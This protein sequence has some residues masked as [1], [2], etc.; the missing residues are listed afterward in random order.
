MNCWP[1]VA[2]WE[3]PQRRFFVWEGTLVQQTQVNPSLECENKTYYYC[4]S[5]APREEL[6]FIWRTDLAK[7]ASG[8]FA[9]S[10]LENS[11]PGGSS[12]N[13]MARPPAPINTAGQSAGS[14]TLSA[15]VPSSRISPKSTVGQALRFRVK[16]VTR[17]VLTS[18]TS[19]DFVTSFGLER[20]YIAR[21][22][23]KP[24][25]THNFH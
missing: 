23:L 19:S 9:S 24:L 15:S 14:S 20:S 11:S 21:K 17:C 10:I 25:F 8:H 7:S 18:N 6:C 1:N 16:S 5:Q 2:N 4:I 12:R 3:S 22:L 13:L